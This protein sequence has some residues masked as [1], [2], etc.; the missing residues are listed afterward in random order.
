MKKNYLNLFQTQLLLLIVFVF[1]SL[2]S[3]AQVT[4]IYTNYLGYWKST[5]TNINSI[6]PEN[7]H[8]VL[9]FTASGTTYSTGV[10]DVI[11]NNQN[12]SYSAQNFRALPILTL[13]TSGGG[14]YWLGFGQ[15]YDGIDNGADTS[16]SN[17]FNAN[18]T[19]SELANYLTTGPQGLDLGTYLT[20]IPNGTSNRFELSSAGLDISNVGDGVPDIFVS[21]IAQPGG[22]DQLRFVNSSG[23]TVGNSVSLSLNSAPTVGKWRT[24][25]YLFNS[26]PSNQINFEKTMRFATLELSQ[27]GIN[28]SNISNAIA[29]IYTPGG[30]SDP[31]FIAYNEPSI[32]VASR[33]NI[34]SQPTTSNCDG[35]MPSNFTIQVTD[36]FG[37][38]VAQSGFN[39]T[40]S[41]KTGPGEL[42]GTLTQTTNVNGEATF[43]NL[44]FE[45][46]GDHTIA[47]NSS[48]LNEEIS[49]TILDATGCGDAEWTGAIDNDW[50]DVGNWN[51][52]EVPNAN[53]NVTIPNT[54][55]NYPVLDIN[56]GADNLILEA[57]ASID[58]NGYLFT[59][60][61]TITA[62]NN[63]FI[64]GSEPNSELS[65][66]GQ[67]AQTIPS[68]FINGDLANLTIANNNGVTVNT[69]IEITE[70]LNVEAG[71]LSTNGN[72]TLK[73]DF[74][75]NTAQLD[76]VTGSISGDIT[77]EQCFPARRA[78]RFVTS[79]V[80]S[81]TSIRE[82]WQENA[83]SYTDNPQ[84]GYGTHITGV[85]EN[86]DGTN[87]FD[88]T[89][90]GLPS[91]YELDN[92]NQSW[93][94]TSN[95][96][97]STLIA[98][99]PYRLMIRGD[100]SIDVTN[101]ETS[102][103]N[104]KLRNTGSVT[105]GATNFSNG[106]SATQG[107][108][109]FFGNPYHAIVDMSEVLV[110]T[111]S[112]NVNKL[113]YYIWDPTQG[114]RGAYST[115]DVLTNSGT[116]GAGNKFLQPMQAGF[117]LTANEGTIPTLTFLEENK[118]VNKP[119]TS[120]FRNANSAEK[121]LHLKMYTEEAYN[122]NQNAS[123][124]LKIKFETSADNAY[125]YKDAPKMFNLD[126]NIARDI[127]GSLSSIEKR[128]LPLTTESL[129]LFTS[130]YKT[131]NYTFTVDLNGLEDYDI[132]IKDNFTG[133]LTLLSN[134]DNAYSFAVD[135]ENSS[136]LSTA[137]DRF[138]LVFEISSLGNEDFSKNE[139]TIYPNPTTGY[140]NIQNNS[141]SQ[142]KKVSIYN[143]LGKEVYTAKSSEIN[144]LNIQQLQAG[145][146]LI[147]AT[148]EAG[149]TIT[150]KIIKN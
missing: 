62:G 41:I 3:Q 79:S 108:F 18:P 53:Y 147:K 24:D 141:D 94:T 86:A 99:K 59:I 107:D 83:S 23:A 118:A 114:T 39:V 98:G 116:I 44:A 40:A 27:F 70:I 36:N 96:N 69:S 9:A 43:T 128:S 2:N 58:L 49:A 105:I 11:L 150:K 87:G 37:N 101:N 120:V 77:T 35:T 55:S 5:S 52:A 85:G 71:Q 56:T 64:D 42:L 112:S 57:G 13:P 149:N 84:P 119:S 111:S 82:N 30:S 103:T 91:M 113:Y 76:Q 93:F 21:Q 10:N 143:L 74:T 14:S 127:N 67:S 1:F 12:I 139:F 92:T 78:Y 73:C 126:E 130:N 33:I 102:A 22:A 68:G 19:G 80:T 61:G 28:A 66:S 131:T 125:T 46:G 34:T 123:D 138:E 32:P 31:A 132:Y 133:S 135:F 140:L 90:S 4:E 106:F 48:S 54:V 63:A 134:T 15:L 50:N 47:F 142:I 97:S 89:P 129:L 45:V 6:Q 136:S 26:Q 137:N 72:I 29:L 65:F 81:S 109:N 38:S 20:N 124:G 144:T 8:A 146:Y 88:F 148:T 51:I 100:R 115:I 75:G 110:N 17:P 145:V 95:T 122:N 117:F 7:S 16:S 60:Q 25:L 121:S 104:T